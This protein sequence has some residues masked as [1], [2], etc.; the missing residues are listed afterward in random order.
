MD[1]SDA[2]A[3]RH[4]VPALRSLTYVPG[5]SR[6]SLP[7]DGD[8]LVAML[9]SS[10]GTLPVV[11][12]ITLDLTRDGN[13]YSAGS[14][15][16]SYR[17]PITGAPLQ[18]Q[19]VAW[20]PSASAR[21]IA[22]ALGALRGVQARAVTELDI[23]GISTNNTNTSMVLVINGQSFS[24]PS[25][26][27]K[28][29]DD[30]NANQVL[31]AK[32]II[33]RSDGTRLRLTDVHGNDIALH[34]AGDPTDSI[35]VRDQQG[36]SL[37]VNGAGP[38]G[39]KH[40]SIGGVVTTQLAPGISLK[41]DGLGL[42]TTNPAHVDTGFGFRLAITGQPEEGDQF[43]VSFNHAAT[44][45]NRNG[46]VLAGFSAA[47]VLGD[48]PVSFGEAYALIVQDVGNVQSEA[49]V[50]REAAQVLLEQ[51]VAARD[52]V[53]GVNLDEEAADL[54]RFE[55]AYNA[56]AQVI[57]AARQIFDTLLDAVR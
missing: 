17:D 55:Q 28:L 31:A 13:G 4:F 38:T 45:D 46:L 57:A 27:N 22:H 19:P 29:A 2:S 3:P 21:E 40:V 50:Q 41:G 23:T 18:T 53:S 56:S 20:G 39:Y 12:S 6:P 14:V 9:G 33:A 25:S 36:Q 7:N 26:L 35:T 42:F 1:N 34:V 11:P 32:G 47:A 15:E 51:S 52:S 48:P 49:N 8:R 37:V 24:E 54:I 16:V 44:S 30:I 10:V 5:S 43:S